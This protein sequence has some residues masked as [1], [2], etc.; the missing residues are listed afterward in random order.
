MVPAGATLQGLLTLVSRNIYHKDRI[1]IVDGRGFSR[2]RVSPSNH[3]KKDEYKDFFFY[4]LNSQHC[5]AAMANLRK[6]L[7]NRD[8][9]C[10]FLQEPYLRKGRVAEFQGL[11]PVFAEGT[12]PRAAMV[13][14][15]DMDIWFCPEY[16]GRDICTSLWVTGTTS[17][18][19]NNDLRI[20]LVSMHLDI[21]ARME[22][23]FPQGW[24]ELVTYCT[25]TNIPLVDT[26]AHSVLWGNESNPRGELIEN[27]V[28]S[29]SLVIENVGGVHTFIARGVQTCMF[30]YL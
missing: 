30:L 16:S 27:Y 22:E 26:N 13:C 29:H 12:N 2:K 28:F 1:N 20:Y 5:Q 4:S 18:Y 15:R 25:R 14:A 24:K 23:I 9:F 3:L 10:L 8:S 7:S 19:N 21:T 6:L 11:S 17:D